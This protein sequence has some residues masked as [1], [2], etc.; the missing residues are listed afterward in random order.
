MRQA[1]LRLLQLEVARRR[2][3]DSIEEHAMPIVRIE[4]F[5]GRDEETK[6]E[7][8]AEITATICKFLGNEPAQVHVVFEEYEPINW[9]TGGAL[10]SAKAAKE[11]HERQRWEKGRWLTEREGA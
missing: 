2:G 8:V 10:W 11:C 9:A 3:E 1:W 5:V 6:S 7:L 4:T